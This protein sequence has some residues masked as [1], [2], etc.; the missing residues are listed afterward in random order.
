[1]LFKNEDHSIEV[2]VS[3]AISVWE[4]DTESNPAGTLQRRTIP[5]LHS[6]LIGAHPLE[7]VALDSERFDLPTY[8]ASNTVLKASPENLSQNT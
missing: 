1:M 4:E 5:A 7:Y 2:V 6:S 8:S 3:Y